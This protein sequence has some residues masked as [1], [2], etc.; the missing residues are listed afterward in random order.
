MN[1]E[2]ARELLHSLILDNPKADRSKVVEMFIDRALKSPKY[3]RPLL[4][5][6]AE[7]NWLGRKLVSATSEEKKRVKNEIVS[8]FVNL[9][10]SIVL[11]TGKPLG[12][13][14]FDEC[15]KAG[16]WLTALAA[17]GKPSEIV[18]DI[19]TTEEV[20]QIWQSANVANATQTSKAKPLRSLAD[21][22]V[23]RNV[24]TA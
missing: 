23:V 21:L 19:L 20:L 8:K 14:T 22:S 11:P 3:W 6:F 15:K 4:M 17:R 10:T 24:I 13:S 1:D 9:L 18:G 7:A 16:G 12:R 2:S 5:N